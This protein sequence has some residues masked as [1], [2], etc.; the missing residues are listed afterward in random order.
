MSRCEKCRLTPGYVEGPP[1][2]RDGK[3]YPTM[4]PCPVC[5]PRIPEPANVDPA[6][7]NNPDRKN[8]RDDA[9]D[10]IDRHPAAA[11]MYV[12]IAH[13]LAQ[14]GKPF[15]IKLVAEQVRYRCHI[16]QL[17]PSVDYLI[18]N[19]H[20]AYIARWLVTQVPALAGLIKF[21]TARYE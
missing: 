2:V 5:R 7:V 6:R 11:R 9:A 14:V 12:E 16:Q 13:E 10:W 18:N 15:G 1:V 19:N 17:K 20:V 8:L 3:T 4:D 21:R